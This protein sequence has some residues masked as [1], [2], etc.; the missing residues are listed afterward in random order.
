MNGR[1]L[2]VSFGIALVVSAVTGAEMVAHSQTGTPTGIDATASPSPTRT[3]TST[4]RRPTA[5]WEPVAT[6][7]PLR[8]TATPTRTRTRTPTR[9]ATLPPAYLPQVLRQ[10]TDSPTATPRPALNCMDVVSDGGFERGLRDW[11]E[12]PTTGEP[13]IRTDRP[14]KGSIGAWF[15][16]FDNAHDWIVSKSDFFF[17]RK[18]GGLSGDL[19]RGRISAS[20]VMTSSENG[21]ETDTLSLVVRGRWGEY[22][23]EYDTNGNPRDVWYTGGCEFPS[24]LMAAA[25]QSFASVVVRGDTSPHRPSGWAVDD[26]KVELCTRW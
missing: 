22:D 20:L 25:S 18:D 3:R 2:A 5:T 16:G 21:R 17:P 23:C 7:T 9:T 10:P 8:R 19:V 24:D 14:H 12:F 13:I 26:V 6:Q 15:A 11:I 4:P 1:T